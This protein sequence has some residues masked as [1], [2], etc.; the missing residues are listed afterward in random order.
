MSARKSSHRTIFLI[1]SSGSPLL[2]IAAS[3][4]SRS[5]K[6]FCPMTRPLHLPIFARGYRVRFAQ[7]WR[8]EFFEAPL[9]VFTSFAVT[10]A[11]FGFTNKVGCILFSSSLPA[12][13]L[14]SLSLLGSRSTLVKTPDNLKVRDIDLN[15]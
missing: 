6:P 8:E 3:L 4:R 10:S 1:A 5:K 2:L 9:G 11:I 13:G 15:D 12:S 7:T 14:A